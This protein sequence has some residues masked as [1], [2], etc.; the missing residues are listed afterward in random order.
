MLLLFFLFT[1]SEISFPIRS[2]T[3]L[4][5][6]D[7]SFSLSLATFNT[8]LAIVRWA[9]FLSSVFFPLSFIPIILSKLR[10]LVVNE[11]QNFMCTLELPFLPPKFMCKS[12]RVLFYRQLSSPFFRSSHPLSSY[13]VRFWQCIMDDSKKHFK[14][15]PF[16]CIAHSHDI[17][18]TGETKFFGCFLLFLRKEV[19]SIFFSHFV[20]SSLLYW[21]LFRKISHLHQASSLE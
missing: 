9:Q 14:S 11:S 2:F 15:L 7:I 10:M 1:S 12:H 4:I 5:Q 17:I 19:F 6:F 21:G 20:L 18:E 8:Y 3:I 13:L 16:K